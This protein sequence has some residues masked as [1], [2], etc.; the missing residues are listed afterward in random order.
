MLGSQNLQRNP[1][2]ARFPHRSR[3][4]PGEVRSRRLDGRAVH[5]R[6]SCARNARHLPP[7]HRTRC[8]PAGGASDLTEAAKRLSAHNSARAVDR[9]L[10][11]VVT[12]E[13]VTWGDAI[14]QFIAARKVKT[15]AAEG[16][17]PPRS[18]DHA[19]HNSVWLRDFA[20]TFPRHA[21]C[22][23]TR[24]H[25][26]AHL[27]QFATSV[28]AGGSGV[29]GRAGEAWRFGGRGDGEASAGVMTAEADG[30]RIA[31]DAGRGNDQPGGRRP[32]R[33]CL[34]GESTGTAQVRKCGTCGPRPEQC[35]GTGRFSGPRR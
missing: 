9:L 34:G 28:A 7:G 23:P 24:P 6:L 1:R 5:R 27:K 17:L 30:G 19:Y 16:R 31:G 20:S 10:K 15:V 26:D 4:D 8:L 29:L 14:E 13:R 12:V 33:R 11:S 2:F 22:D 21:I 32:W 35:G 3:T 18:P 25:R